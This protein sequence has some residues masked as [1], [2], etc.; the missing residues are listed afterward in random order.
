MQQTL[1]ILVQ[2]N[3]IQYR[4][5]R[6]FLF[7]IHFKLYFTSIALTS[8]IFL[9]RRLYNSSRQQFKD[10]KTIKVF[11]IQIVIQ[12]LFYYLKKLLVLFFTIQRNSL[13]FLFQIM[14]K[15]KHFQYKNKVQLIQ[16]QI[17]QDTIY[18]VLFTNF[19]V[20]Q[21]TQNTMIIFSFQNYPVQEIQTY[22]IQ[23]AVSFNLE[24]IFYLNGYSDPFVLINLSDY[25]SYLY[26][27]SSSLP[28]IFDP[29]DLNMVKVFAKFIKPCINVSTQVDSYHLYF[30]CPLNTQIYDITS[31]QYINNIKYLASEK[32]YMKSIQYVDK[33]I[34]L[35]LA[36]NK[37]DRLWQKNI[38]LINRN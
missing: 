20:I 8:F 28:I 2:Q 18:Q 32:S 37:I 5:V 23:S 6:N 35:V 24:Q 7:Q 27:L 3:M 21:Q 33:N 36:N 10:I 16:F 26:K 13:S 30:I 31:M 12:L 9:I 14:N 4:I 29:S 38:I 25:F 1:K 34:F 19:Q 17:N 22:Q 11:S 15:N